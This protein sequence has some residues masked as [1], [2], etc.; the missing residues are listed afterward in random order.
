MAELTAPKREFFSYLYLW[1]LYNLYILLQ[2]RCKLSNSA[3]C[4]SN[5][6]VSGLS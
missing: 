5:V 6:F 1:C 4:Y 2:N 3:N